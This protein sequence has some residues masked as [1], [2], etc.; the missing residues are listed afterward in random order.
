MRT[1]SGISCARAFARDSTILRHVGLI[2]LGGGGFWFPLSLTLSCV[3]GAFIVQSRVKSPP[4]GGGC[5]CVV[6]G[7]VAAKLF[8]EMNV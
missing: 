8:V 4:P 5:H 7:A 6:Y 1:W 3:R 2:F